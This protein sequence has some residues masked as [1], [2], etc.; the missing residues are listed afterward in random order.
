MVDA[1]VIHR[2]LQEVLKVNILDVF[3]SRE[4]FCALLRPVACPTLE[5]ILPRLVLTHVVLLIDA[6]LCHPEG[7]CHD[8]SES[9]EH[10]DEPIEL[11]G[12]QRCHGESRVLQRQQQMTYREYSD[13]DADC[14]DKPP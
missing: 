5:V 3:V 9:D 4:S 11:R 2:C 13:N 14:Q 12:G 7:T 6:I 8:A 1:K 10:S